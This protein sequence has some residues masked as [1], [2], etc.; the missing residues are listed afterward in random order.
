M[1]SCDT[2]IR[3]RYGETDQMG[4]LHHSNYALYFEVARVE[5]MRTLGFPYGD[6]EKKGILMPVL[7]VNSKFLQPIWYDELVTVRAIITEIPL[8]RMK[9]NYE[10][11]NDNGNISSKGSTD[12][13]FVNASTRKPMRCPA[14][15]LDLLHPVFNP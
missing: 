14:E 11:Y 12:L 15:I 3:V 5:L 10:V 1:F 4:Y 13:C 7:H 8:S 6:M 9:L 2:Q